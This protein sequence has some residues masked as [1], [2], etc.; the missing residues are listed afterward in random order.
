MKSPLVACCLVGWFGMAAMLS[1]AGPTT[2]PAAAP[3]APASHPPR[4]LHLEQPEHPLALLKGGVE[5][6]ALI[7][8]SVD[9]R[10]AVVDAKVRTATQPEFGEA[11]RTAVFKWKFEPGLR[12]GRPVP[13]DLEMPFAF[14][15]VP[16]EQLEALAGRKVF[17]TIDALIVPAEQLRDWPTPREPTWPRYPEKLKGTGTEGKAVVAFVIDRE[18]RTVNPKLIKTT[19]AEF[20]LPAMVTVLRMN[21]GRLKVRY[22]AVCVGMRLQFNFSEK[23][24]TGG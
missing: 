6:E 9:E 8:C 12:D 2:A 19:H 24:G 18:G 22:R 11:A 3:A 14:K 10:G 15:I 4:P 13:F 23:D 5:G 21:F 16:D 7:V 17:V 20:I 1:G